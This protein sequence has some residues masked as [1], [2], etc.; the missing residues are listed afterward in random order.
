LLYRVDLYG[1]LEL[2]SDEMPQFLSELEQVLAAAP[3]DGEHQV[4][5]AVHSL[6]ERCRDETEAWPCGSLATEPLRRP[7]LPVRPH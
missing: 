5:E 7:A 6:A 4:I 1:T 3:D 2:S